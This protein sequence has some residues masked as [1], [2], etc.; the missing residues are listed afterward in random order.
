MAQM[1]FHLGNKLQGLSFV[2]EVNPHK[3]LQVSNTNRNMGVV[4][5][6]RRFSKLNVVA[7]E[8]NGSIVRPG[9]EGAIG[10]NTP[11]TTYYP[12]ARVA[13]PA[14]TERYGR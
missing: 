8:L 3:S 1:V 9:L 5:I 6:I 2:W 7:A 12:A 10:T 4:F 11:C 14:E 13:Y